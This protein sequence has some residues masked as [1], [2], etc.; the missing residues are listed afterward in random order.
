LPLVLGRPW[1]MR[2][3]GE[4]SRAA[5]IGWQIRAYFDACRA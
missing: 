3:P 4:D 2:R 5:D 1:L